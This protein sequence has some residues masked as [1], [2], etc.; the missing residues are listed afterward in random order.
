MRSLDPSGVAIASRTR[1]RTPPSWPVARRPSAKPDQS[2]E[3]DR[4]GRD[5]RLLPRR[6]F[7][8]DHPSGNHQPRLDLITIHRLELQLNTFPVSEKRIWEVERGGSCDAVLPMPPG[9]TLSAGD[10]VL[11]ALACSNAGRETC[12]VK[13]GDSVCVLLTEVIDLGAADPA[14]GQALFRLSWK[15]PGQSGG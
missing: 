8:G 11:F 15:P 13:G 5:D 9:K 3:P 10:L 7:A 12:Y 4:S 14:T 1:A 2:P 6:P